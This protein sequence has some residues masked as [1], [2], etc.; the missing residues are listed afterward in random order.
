MRMFKRPQ[1]YKIVMSR[2]QN[3]MCDHFV[4]LA[5]TGDCVQCVYGEADLARRHAR[6][7]AALALVNGSLALN[8]FV[9]LT[10]IVW[11]AI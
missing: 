2:H 8:L 5:Q 11:R 1:P 9:Y 7:V 10:E 3:D 6:R 4:D